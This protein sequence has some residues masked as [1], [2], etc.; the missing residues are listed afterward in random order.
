MEKLCSFLAE[1]GM[2]PRLLTHAVPY[3]GVWLEETLTGR[4]MQI[5]RYDPS[6]QG[7][8]MAV[9]PEGFSALGIPALQRAMV[10]EGTWTVIDEIGF[11]EREELLYQ[12]TLEQLFAKKRVLAAVRQG[13]E[14]YL[15]RWKKRTD[16]FLV[17]LDTFRRQVG[18]VILASGESRRFGENKLFA[19]WQGK[20]FLQRILE[21]TEGVFQKR[22]VVTRSK[23]AAA[24]CQAQGVEVLL[25]SLPY[26][27]DT[28]RLGIAQMTEME[29]VVF[30]P[31]DQPLLQ[32]ESLLRLRNAF[33]FG[34]G[35]LLRLGDGKRMGTPALFSEKYFSE[36]SALPVGKGGGYLLEKYK[37]QVRQVLVKDPLE[38]Y[39]VDTKAEL[40][41]LEQ[42]VFADL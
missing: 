4:T 11:L 32:K 7:R 3:Q 1:E 42:Q 23:E 19:T 30:C 25:H 6:Q 36:L 20:S 17:D 10:A 12:E 29:A 14:A 39:D 22:L 38:L 8:P 41:W 16:A 2:L 13:E 18:C 34:E 33:S 5:G 40:A 9:V 31:C 15:Q 28:V 24:Y 27:S 21:S 35:E 37:E 26:R